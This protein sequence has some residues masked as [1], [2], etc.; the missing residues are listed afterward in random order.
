VSESVVTES[1]GSVDDVAVDE[2]Q[3]A[4]AR[5]LAALLS[6]ATIDSLIAD[7]EA[8][9]MGL[10]GAQGLFSQ[11]TKAV[12]ERTLQLEMADHLGYEKGDLA[13][14]GSGN[15]RNGSTSKNVITNSGPVHVNVPR[16]RAGTFEPKIVP[17][18]ARRLGSVDDMILS[19]YSRGMTTRDIK[20]HLAEVY[21]ADVSPGLI[22]NVTDVV[23]DEITQW[24]TRPL[25]AV[26]PIMYID[27]VVVKIREGG[28]VDNRA[29]HL[30]IGVDVDGFKHVLGIWIVDNEGAKF[31][32]NVLNELVN[33]GVKDVLIVCCDGLTGLPDAIANVWPNAI[34]QTCVVHLIRASTRFVS[35]ADRKAVVKGLRPIYEAVNEAAAR[36]ALN[37]LKHNW[38]QKY[39]GLIST[40]ERSWE[41][42]IPFL[43]FHPAIRKVI[44]TT[45][46]IESMNYQ[47]RKISKTRGHFP[48]PESAIKLLYL[49]IR[50]ITGRHIDGEGQFAGKRGTGTYGW[51]RA[52]NAFATRFGDRMPL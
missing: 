39:T 48:S 40:W 27:A 2:Q 50:N 6:P 46:A 19:L 18:R 24:Q 23:V 45:N 1:T 38:G 42:F 15:S 31:W 8:S 20:E 29:A 12:L 10:D 49:G 51:N 22:S 26:Y 35:Q 7:T 30:A 33:R 32:Q 21:G 3:D 4:A 37:D 13:G 25:D 36:Q 44:Y 28:T 5:R 17:K 11:M 47:L 52:H 16:D 34:V 9:G 41:E 14:R 43:E